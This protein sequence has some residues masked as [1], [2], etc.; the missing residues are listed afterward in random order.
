MRDQPVPSISM[1]QNSLAT[2]GVSINK[3]S[4][5]YGVHS[6]QGT[7]DT[8]SDEFE[9]LTKLKLSINKAYK[10]GKYSDVVIKSKD[11]AEIQA[12]KLILASQ[13]KYFTRKFDAQPDAK[14]LEI[15]EIK[16]DA[17][18]VII[19][20]LYT[21]KVK[22]NLVNQDNA[23]DILKAGEMFNIEEVKE[24]AAIFMA[25]NLDEENAIDVMTNDMFAGA[26]SNNAFTYVANHFQLFLEKDHLKKRLLSELNAS[27]LCHLLSQK[28]M[29]L[30]DKN[31]IY[32][33]ALEREKQLFFFV[34]GFVAHDNKNR[35]PD[36]KR[37]LTCLKLPIL[38]AGKVLS[39]VIMG[40]GLETKPEELAG[41]LSE[42]LEPF[43]DLT[44][45]E[46]LATMFAND[47]KKKR[48]Q[49]ERRLLAD[50]C[51]MRYATI[52]HSTAC[53][54]LVN[55]QQP[56][57]EKITFCPGS[58]EQTTVFSN[59]KVVRSLTVFTSN[60]S[61]KEKEKP[62]DTNQFDRR[63]SGIKIK[64]EDGK[65]ESI[66]LIDHHTTK[67]ETYSLE[68]GEFI[69]EVNTHHPTALINKP[70]NTFEK[71]VYSLTT[72]YDLSFETNQE[73]RVG[74][75]KESDLPLG[76]GLTMKVPGKIR[77]LEKNCPG[78]FCWLQGFGSEEIKITGSSE[79]KTLYPIWGFQTHFKV[80]SVKNQEFD[81]VAG[82]KKLYQFS[83]EGLSENP[84]IDDLEDIYQVERSP[85]H[86]VVDLEDSDS[87][88]EE[89][90]DEATQTGMLNN[91]DSIMVVDSDSE[92]EED[93][94]EDES[95]EE[96]GYLPHGIMP[97]DDMSFGYPP[98]NFRPP[99]DDGQ[100]GEDEPIEIA[101]SSDGDTPNLADVED[102]D[103]ENEEETT[104]EKSK[105][106]DK[107]DPTPKDDKEEKKD[108]GKGKT[109]SPTNEQD[110]EKQNK[111]KDKEDLQTNTNE[112][113]KN[114]TEKMDSSE[115]D[116]PETP[117]KRSK[118]GKEIPAPS[119][120]TK[121]GKEKKSPQ[122]SKNENKEV[123]KTKTDDKSS[124]GTDKES[125]KNGQTTKE[126][127]KEN[128]DEVSDK[129]TKRKKGI[130][131]ESDKTAEEIPEKKGRPK[132]GAD[133]ESEKSVDE[134]PG[135]KKK[136]GVK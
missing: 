15:S 78:K 57:G 44:G 106:K 85:V 21:Q 69:T 135:K 133:A 107:K 17:I 77:H 87:N 99:I 51:K 18:K 115:T 129:K 23:K 62:D 33:D 4:R 49:S 76:I 68:Q 2:H 60:T 108:K 119:S 116:Q 8:V 50:S 42:I 111:D 81:F 100:G 88:S 105:G 97:M 74:P 131:S 114:D 13:S 73:R 22:S 7:Q 89:S 102:E 123:V 41:M 56:W 71:E 32:L 38:V 124:D 28:N 126:N 47:K 79:K 86:E 64:F 37:I 110:K 55:A 24:E 12:H 35:L 59:N 16:G 3:T 19:D 112:E 40:K 132:R 90:S 98:M 125:T 83:I 104:N 95:D 6:M 82:I 92:E 48:S 63:V 127:S 27:K 136:R 9:N 10:Q 80:Y 30:W 61:V 58:T 84:K 96:S 25:K 46:N 36:L 113:E 94:E 5:M 26:I 75:M 43:D 39:V 67:Q 53:S 134:T 14:E 128:G 70:G 122:K 65:E 45:K 72:I 66:G 91:D 117:S 31:G 130:E 120:I 109:D 54:D 34:M 103:K 20:Y 118:R 52:P 93:G 11:G 121:K 1:L 101:S 29:M